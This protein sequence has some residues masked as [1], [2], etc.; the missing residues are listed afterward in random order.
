MDVLCIECCYWNLVYN[1]DLV[2]CVCIELFEGWGVNVCMEC[3]VGW[4]E[5]YG[6]NGEEL[7]FESD[8]SYFD[9]WIYEVIDFV[10]EVVGKGDVL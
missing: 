1:I 5:V 3:D 4:V 9:W 8:V 6:L 10:I 2:Q 7:D